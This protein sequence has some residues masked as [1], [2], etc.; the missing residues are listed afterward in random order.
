MQVAFFCIGEQRRMI[1]FARIVPPAQAWEALVA[2][3]Q[4][5][6][7]HSLPV[8]DWIVDLNLDDAPQR[9]IQYKDLRRPVL[10]CAVKRS[11]CELQQICGAEQVL[12]GLNAFP[13]M[14]DASMLEVSFP[15]ATSAQWFASL[16][17]E[18]N[19]TWRQAGTAR[20]MITPRIIAM[21]INEAYFS[22]HHGISSR[23]DIDRAMK[24]GT[25]YPWGPF[26]WC[27]RIGI[28]DVYETLQALAEHDR[29]GRY[30]ICPLLA[31][32]YRKYKDHLAM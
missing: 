14:L 6:L 21:I 18:M 10:G 25:N 29:S 20:G 24:W 11:V 8:S 1:D 12:V 27:D 3:P 4:D 28:G 2:N 26:E 16:A 15:D 30:E 32:A 13:T 19:W 9:L 23:E 22:L 5:A 31:E 7:P 17:E